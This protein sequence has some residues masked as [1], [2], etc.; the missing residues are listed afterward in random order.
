MSDSLQP[1]ELQHARPPCPSPTPGVYSNSCSL[2][3]WFHPTILFFLFSSHLQSFPTSESFPMSLFFPS[4]IQS[5]GVSA[6]TSVLPMN[7]QNWFPLGLTGWIFL[8]SRSLLQHH[9][10]KISV[11]QHLAFLMV[12]FSHP[13]MTTRKTIA[14]TKWTFVSKV[15]SLLFNMLSRL[16][17][18]FL[19]RSKPLLISLSAEIL[20]PKKIKSVTVLNASHLFATKWWDWMPWT[21]FF[22]CWV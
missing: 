17:I 6:S 8:Q 13:Y 16:V 2:S 21:Q 1:H 3:W 20:E 5:I 15:M 18:V 14:L 9:S 12:Q 4:G 7:I 10:L 11:P 19:L 22:E